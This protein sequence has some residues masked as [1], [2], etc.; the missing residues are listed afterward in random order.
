MTTPAAITGIILAAGEGE[1]MGGPKALLAVRWGE[2]PGELPLAIA[3]ARSML[4]GGVKRV[5]VVTRGLRAIGTPIIT[6]YTQR[7]V[8]M[9]PRPNWINGRRSPTGFPFPL[10]P[11]ARLRRITR[12]GSLNVK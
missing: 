7:N 4:D 9:K 8:A 5:V 2:G 3:H 10:F 1:R 12:H 11:R 6:T